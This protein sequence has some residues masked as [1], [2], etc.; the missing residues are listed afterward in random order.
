MFRGHR[1]HSIHSVCVSLI[2]T[3][4]ST[5]LIRCHPAHPDPVL[6]VSS[7]CDIR[8]MHFPWSQAMLY[9]QYKSL[10]SLS[11]VLVRAPYLRICVKKTSS[12]LTLSRFSFLSARAQRR[13]FRRTIHRLLLCCVCREQV[14]RV[15]ARAFRRGPGEQPTAGEDRRLEESA[16]LVSAGKAEKAADHLP[17][18]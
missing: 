5:L 7:Y 11:S 12:S 3:A 16:A 17:R 1:L 9:I 8:T 6:V 4:L 2:K 18:R 14:G 13:K 15:G 10:D